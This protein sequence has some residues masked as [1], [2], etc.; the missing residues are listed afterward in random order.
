MMGSGVGTL[1]L[2]I[3]TGPGSTNEKITWQLSGNQGNK[4]RE[5]TAPI[6]SRQDF[7]V[8]L[9]RKILELFKKYFN[10]LITN[11]LKTK[12]F[13]AWYP[14]IDL[15]KINVPLNSL[16]WYNFVSF[17]WYS[18]LLQGKTSVVIFQSMISFTRLVDAR[19]NRKKPIRNTSLPLLQQHQQPLCVSR[20]HFDSYYELLSF[21]N[22]LLFKKKN[23][24]YLVVNLISKSYGK[25]LN[26]I[27]YFIQLKILSTTYLFA[28]F[29][30]TLNKGH[31]GKQN[32]CI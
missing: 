20:K 9:K 8:S 11:R 10:N 1:N 12:T 19:F 28:L 23:Y 26:F 25:L 32:F 22:Q 2:F 6:Y 24:I 15:K 14:G 21:K 17:S 7:Y 3:K 5:G 13:S 27:L 30:H 29:M 18:K 4:W 31:F 16:F